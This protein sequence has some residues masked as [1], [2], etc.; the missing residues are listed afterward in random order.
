MLNEYMIGIMKLSVFASLMVGISH[1][2]MKSVTKMTMG[3]LVISVVMLPIVDIIKG[4][5]IEKSLGFL[6]NDAEIGDQGGE[7]AES[8]FEEGISE[9]ISSEYG[10]PRDRITVNV[11]GFSLEEMRA[12]RVY[13]SLTLKDAANIDYRRLERLLALNFTNGGECEVSLIVGQ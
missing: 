12:Q 4:F 8:A 7:L 11:D 10:I 5:D 6:D 9:Y 2:R 1:D 13:A 3:V